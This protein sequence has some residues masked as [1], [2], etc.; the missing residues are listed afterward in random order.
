MFCYRDMTFCDFYDECIDG[1]GC[2]RALTNKV[3][4]AARIW[5]KDPPIC[6]FMKRPECFKEE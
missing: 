2:P 3:L 6:T 5:M 1:E 4:A